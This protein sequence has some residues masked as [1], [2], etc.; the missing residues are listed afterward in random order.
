[1]TGSFDKTAKVWNASSGALL[2]TFHG[3]AN[4][5][6]ATEF[7]VHNDDE[8]A[9]ASMDGTSRIFRVETG[10]ETHNLVGHE[11]AIISARFDNDGN[12]LLTGSFDGTAKVWDLRNGK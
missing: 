11:D 10:Q 6:V 7:N 8:I 9:T 3:H 5:I 2:R 1:M 4:E 12:L